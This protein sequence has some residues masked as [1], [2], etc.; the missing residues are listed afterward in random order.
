M[1]TRQFMLFLVA[2]LMTTA[3]HAG[4]VRLGVVQKNTDTPVSFVFKNTGDA[5]VALGELKSSCS[6]L[7]VTQLPT[8]VAAGESVSISGVYRSVNPGKIEVVALLTGQAP[9][10]VVKQFTVTGFVVE[11]DWLVTVEEAATRY[12]AGDI[13]I[14]D[15]RKSERYE[16]AY[17]PRSIN[18]LSFALRTR[19]DLRSSS[20]VLV[21]EGFAPDVLLTE[22]M[23]MRQ[24]GFTRVQVLQGGIPLW[25][26]R[27]LPIVGK[28]IDTQS[29][30]KISAADFTR[31]SASTNWAVINWA[32]SQSG[33]ELHATVEK[34]FGP[35]L[36][37]A[38]SESGYAEVEKYV[39]RSAN[40]AVVYYLAGGIAELDAFRQTRA[41]IADNSG[42]T[43]QIK[44]EHR[45]TFGSTSGC[46]S[47]PN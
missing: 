4:S 23:R 3:L 19:S 18:L 20:L 12:A 5:S 30:A 25:A 21:D 44:A 10:S 31:A 16:E 46:G 39:V 1:M 2:G 22:L 32:G 43:F 6:C 47:C 17:I 33:S 35:L 8:S 40:D 34:T 41:A 14:L 42:Q 15:T 45:A 28:R 13:Q 11:P 29:L 26:R 24:Q 27:G 36:V 37:V 7:T 38:S 9:S